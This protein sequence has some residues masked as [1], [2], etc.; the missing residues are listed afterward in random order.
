MKYMGKCACASTQ[1]AV[2]STL[3]LDSLIP[4]VCDCDYCQSL[5]L[6][7][8]LVSEPQ[9]SIEIVTAAAGLRRASNGSGQATFFHCQQC[10]Q[11]IAVGAELDN[12]WQGAVNCCLFQP[13]LA[14][15][16]PVAI[17]PRLLPAAEKRQRWSALWG[18]LTLTDK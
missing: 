6:D 16:E 2:E 8:A 1:V 13:A 15:A 14:F 11:L 9:L 10:D 12:G 7:A 4:R 18:R 5:T 17:Q 3:A